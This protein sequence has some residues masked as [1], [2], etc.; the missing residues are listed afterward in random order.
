MTHTNWQIIPSFGFDTLCLLNILTGDPFYVEFNQQAYEH[1]KPYI[2]PE[3][4]HALADL[5][6]VIKDEGQSIISAQ[7][8][9]FFSAVKGETL[10]DMQQV[11]DNPTPMQTSLQQSPYYDEADWQRFLSS[12]DDLR[13]IFNFL[14]AIDFSGYWQRTILPEIKEN[15]QSIESYLSE[16]DVVGQ[17][18]TLIGYRLSSP[19]ITVY[20]LNYTRPHGIKLIGQ[21]F[22][23]A[24]SWRPE[25]VLRT[26]I[27]E[28]LHPP[29]DL[30][31]DQPLQVAIAALLQDPFIAG[32][33]SAHN[34]DFGYNE[35][36]GY[37]EEN[38]VRALDQLV[39]E[40]F[41]IARN[42][43]ERWREE[44]EAMHVLAAVLY[45]T[46]KSQ[47]FMGGFRNF[48]TSALQTQLMPGNV[49]AI[50]DAFYA[51]QV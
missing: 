32:K 23:T 46:M 11:L 41:N 21:R 25:I 35:F 29:Y 40:A 6:R 26:A 38:C 42:P 27:H 20:V 7:L 5:K 15:I 36:T 31:A 16:Y 45:H 10:S 14:E 37:V 24:A 28:M 17:L 39:S 43:W 12:R 30:K 19:S 2:T 22:I 47:H 4:A 9:L 51:S 8:C 34:P 33:F 49:R 1:F 13:M 18:E 3:V 50:Y 48:L 44:D